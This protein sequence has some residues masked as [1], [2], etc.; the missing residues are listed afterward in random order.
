MWW[1]ELQ[2]PLL[3]SGLPEAGL[4]D[5]WQCLLLL[6]RMRSFYFFLLLVALL[7]HKGACT[8]QRVSGSPTKQASL[9]QPS[10][11][12]APSA[13]GWGTCVCFSFCLQSS[14]TSCLIT[15]PAKL[16]SLWAERKGA[17]RK[18]CLAAARL[19]HPVAG[20]EMPKLCPSSSHMNWSCGGFVKASGRGL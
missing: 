10:A 4:W 2:H 18:L 13:G 19:S 1:G 6:Q 16:L 17:G 5:P 20:F 14:S 15:Q 8:V 12:W 7:A 9:R 3:S 11:L